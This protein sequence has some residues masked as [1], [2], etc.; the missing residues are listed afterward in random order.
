MSQLIKRRTREKIG[1]H[2]THPVGAEIVSEL[3]RDVPSFGNL[4][5]RFCRES[6]R[7]IGIFQ[8][9]FS[10]R[11]L[12]SDAGNALLGFT[13]FLRVA[14][15]E[16]SSWSVLVFP[17]P[18]TNKALYSELHRSIAMPQVANWLSA[19]RPD[20]WF[21]GHHVLQIGASNDG[22]EV[23]L[24]ETHGDRIVKMSQVVAGKVG[25]G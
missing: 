17:V 14:W 4:S 20:T 5:L 11:Y 21:E 24:L 13:E 6:G 22:S 16:Y 10:L 25:E 23:A 9:G 2:L 18:T 3:L 7:K 8:P 12:K 15:S 19:K 1:K